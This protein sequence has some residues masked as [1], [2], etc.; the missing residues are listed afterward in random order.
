[1]KPIGSKN[2]IPDSKDIA[3]AVVS[4]ESLNCK[5]H[6]LLSAFNAAYQLGKRGGDPEQGFLDFLLEIAK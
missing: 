5:V 2:T 6:A 3:D 1:M 4:N